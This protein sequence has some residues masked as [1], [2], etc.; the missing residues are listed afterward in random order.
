MYDVRMD[1]RKEMERYLD[2]GKE[3]GMPESWKE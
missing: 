1:V 2:V 3:G